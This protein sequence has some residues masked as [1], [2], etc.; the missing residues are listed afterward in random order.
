MDSVVIAISLAVLWCNCEHESPC[1]FL[2]FTYGQSCQFCVAIC[3]LIIFFC[4]KVS[5]SG[6]AWLGEILRLLLESS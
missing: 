3:Q 5:F 2:V 6:V 4:E 1:S